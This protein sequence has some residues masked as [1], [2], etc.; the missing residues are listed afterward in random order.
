MVNLQTNGHSHSHVHAH[1]NGNGTIAKGANGV[2]GANGPAKVGMKVEKI[3]LTP[4]E[5]PH[6]QESYS[7]TSEYAF[8]LGAG[9]S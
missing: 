2:H 7:S 9:M 4:N 1:S 8:R 5:R 3:A 6:P